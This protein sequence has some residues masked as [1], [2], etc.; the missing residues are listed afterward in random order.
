MD[1]FQATLLGITQGL[2]E[3]LPVSSSGH[4]VLLET[5]MGLKIAPRDL[6]SFDVILHA[7]TALA[8]LVC[9]RHQWISILSS[10]FKNNGQKKLL[11]LLILASIPGAAAGVLFND[12]LAGSFRSVNSVAAALFVTGL[13]LLLAHRKRGDDT[14]KNL[15]GG[16]AL[17]IGFAQALALIPGISRSGMTISAGQ[18]LGMKRKE[19]LDFSFLM[20][21]PI[22]VGASVFTAKDMITGE[23][24]LPPTQILIVG[25]IVSFFV[26]IFA[27][28]ILRKFV[29]KHSLAWFSVYLIP[30]SLVLYF[31]A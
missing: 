3:F 30:V 19:A 21:F 25:F 8:L 11:G 9:Y 18:L 28:L 2:T 16:S 13:V 27:I 17:S 7:G 6:L 22:I 4:L 12:A 10:P 15:K 31:S 29:V 14:I 24:L 26:S 5:F 1:A 20:A 23:V